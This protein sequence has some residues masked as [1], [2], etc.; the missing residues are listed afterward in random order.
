MI[1]Y[2]DGLFTLDTK[3]TTYAFR[4][5]KSGHL[6]HLYYGS[7][8]DLSGMGADAL[9]GDY[10]YQAGNMIAYSDEFP[11]L[12]MENVNL[13]VSSY[14]KGDTREP[15]VLIRHTDGSYTSDFVYESHQINNGH[16]SLKGLPSS[17]AE[18]ESD[19]MNVTI[20]LRSKESKVFLELVYTVYEEC[21]CITRSAKIRNQE[22]SAI[23]IERIMSAQLDFGDAEYD[24]IHFNGAWIREMNLS[25]TRCTQGKQVN[26]SMMGVSS[27]RSNPY[28]MLA[29]QET[30][31]YAGDVYA[32][33][34]I[35]S[36]NH[37]ECAEVGSYQNLR[38]VAGI[39]PELFC[40]DLPAG[41]EFQAPEAVLSYSDEGFSGISRNMHTF[42]K[43]HI[44][45]GY[46]KEKA[47]PVLFNSWEACYFKFDENKLCKLA[48]KAKNLGMEL[49]VLDDGWFGKREDDK[50]SLGDWNCNLKK[51]PSGL[52]GLASKIKAIGMDFGIWV[53]PEMVS[54]DSDCY[55]AH[56]EWAVD[57]PGKM[58]SEGRHQRILNLTMQEVREYVIS[59][60]SDLLDSA[61]I[62]YVKWDMNRIF[63]DTYGIGLKNQQEFLHRYVLGLY[64]ILDQLMKRFP[65]VLFEGCASGGNRFDLGMLCYFPQIW[66]SDNTDAWCRT[67]IQT[68]YSYGYPM[69]V[70]SA[71]VSASP[72]HQTLRRIPLE[73]RYE[74][75]L[76]GQL[77]YECNILDLPD[78]ELNAI[79]EQIVFYQNNREWLFDGSF[80]RVK[81]GKTT[82]MGNQ[83]YSWMLVSK[84]QK[85]AIGMQIQDKTAANMPYAVFK[86]AGLSDHKMYHF[87]NQKL[88]YN[89]KYFGDLINTVAPVHVKQDSLVHNVIARFVKM[90]GETE[91]YV[92]SGS[93]LNRH[94][95]RLKQ[96]YCA[97]GYDEDV[98]YYQDYGSRLYL[99][100]QVEEEVSINKD[101]G[102]N[103]NE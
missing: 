94:G 61:D 34:L 82:P 46:W 29:R 9:S 35:Y 95:I 49:F 86:T 15:F 73:T 14:G 26:S 85:H 72:N 98:R 93:L 40:Y 22:Q 41:F 87:Y 39:N 79:R 80:Y 19:A 77:G 75:A 59:Q 5:M 71:H 38:M 6:K 66:A 102:D 83:E 90:D 37:Y 65:E 84:D 74:V 32:C 30:T 8:I 100:E 4:I 50:T 48:K 57:I 7:S 92:V 64:E 97:T 3:N 96:N 101:L 81:T 52:S 42:V 2:E 78:E 56:P 67:Q 58:H 24:F 27:N 99:M 11:E 28:V 43:E 54:V 13:E 53:E 23:E 103:D 12:T 21:D 91:D 17:Y 70:I 68:G 20:T 18:E 16:Q 60:M 88:S 25:R 55:R 33:N 76:F 63:S 44:V 36:G 45:R 31:E 69:S 10:K 51:I 62:R 1:R 47:R 89:V